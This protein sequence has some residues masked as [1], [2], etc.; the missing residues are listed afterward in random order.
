MDKINKPNISEEILILTDG[1]YWLLCKCKYICSNTRLWWNFQLLTIVTVSITIAVDYYRNYINYYSNYN[2][3][4]N[5]CVYSSG[6]LVNCLLI[7]FVIELIA[8]L[9]FRIINLIIW[10]IDIRFLTN[11]INYFVVSQLY[12]N[13][14]CSLINYSHNC[15]L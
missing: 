5:N 4:Y 1:L 3:L 7:T 15:I 2:N 11:W 9:I 6:N 13:F 14:I 10:L 12:F 8:L